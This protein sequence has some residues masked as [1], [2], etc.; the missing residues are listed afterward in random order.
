MSPTKKPECGPFGTQE[1][2]T[3]WLANKERIYQ[4][5]ARF[6]ATPPPNHTHK[7]VHLMCK[8]LPHPVFNFIRI[9]GSGRWTRQAHY[10]PGGGEKTLTVR[11][12]APGS[13][14]S[15]C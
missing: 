15:E 1:L 13:R 12:A 8:T 14:T 11:G 7:K 9:P 3:P 6:P 5:A 2:A 4:P 10:F